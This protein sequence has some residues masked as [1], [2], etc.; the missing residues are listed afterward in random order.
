MPGSRQ[1]CCQE[2][3]KR[4]E[5]QVCDSRVSG[6]PGWPERPGS[7]EAGGVGPSLLGS[8]AGCWQDEEVTR[9]VSG[10]WWGDTVVKIGRGLRRAEGTSGERMPGPGGPG[11]FVCLACP[12]LT[13]LP[14]L[15]LVRAPTPWEREHDS[16]PCC[17]RADPSP[18]TGAEQAL[19]RSWS[20]LK[21]AMGCRRSLHGQKGWGYREE[22]KRPRTMW[23]QEV[24][25]SRHPNMASGELRLASPPAHPQPS[26]ASEKPAQHP[27][28]L[29]Q[30]ATFF[31]VENF[32]FKESDFIFIGL[33]SGGK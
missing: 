29:E 3:I 2:V 18:E 24:P 14:P 25:H 30:A 23:F 26:A 13:T 11:R 5:Q 31:C 19:T 15:S 27:A 9:V 16:G 21:Q 7:W 22:Q 6:R 12:S 1:G 17:S 20:P 8:T 4:E 33:D 10:S 28:P 32:C